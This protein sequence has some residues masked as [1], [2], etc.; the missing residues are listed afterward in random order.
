MRAGHASDGQLRIVGE[1]GPD[2]DDYGVNQRAQ[3]VE[4]SKTI[5]AIDVMRMP[6]ERGHAAIQRLADLADDRATI[7]AQCLQRAEHVLPGGR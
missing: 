6:R 5:G 3:A 7:L 2:P 1:R 4:V